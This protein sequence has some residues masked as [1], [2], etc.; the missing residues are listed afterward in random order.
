MPGYPDARDRE[1]PQMDEDEASEPVRPDLPALEGEVLSDSWRLLRLT[2]RGP[3][4]D[5]F[6]GEQLD[7]GL[8]A[9]IWVLSPRF[10]GPAVLGLLRETLDTIN[11]EAGDVRW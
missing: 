10:G 4:G 11:R 7:T 2:A 9:R 6:D 5:L 1:R 3:A 8:R